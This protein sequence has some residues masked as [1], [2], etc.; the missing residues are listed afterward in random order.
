MLLFWINSCSRLTLQGGYHIHNCCLC[1]VETST[2]PSTDYA[3]FL[4]P[5]TM[6]SVSIKVCHA[7]QNR[8]W[9]ISI[10]VIF[11]SEESTILQHLCLRELFVATEN[12]VAQGTGI[13]TSEI[14]LQTAPVAAPSSGTA[15]TTTKTTSTSPS[16]INNH[17]EFIATSTKEKRHLRSIRYQN[18]LPCF[19]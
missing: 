7:Y 9:I 3:V 13:Q 10:H 15:A 2:F 12:E 14:L 18:E 16:S 11:G 8:P 5:I 19:L 17:I 1:S 4:T 6:V